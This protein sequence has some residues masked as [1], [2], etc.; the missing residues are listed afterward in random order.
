MKSACRAGG[1]IDINEVSTAA[2]SSSIGRS[3]AFYAVKISDSK[4]S[5]E[6]SESS[7]RQTSFSSVP[8]L[9]FVSLFVFA[10]SLQQS[11]P[12]LAALAASSS[13]ALLSLFV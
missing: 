8:L 12:V 5:F 3:L 6:V 4:Q 7:D 10:S 1:C 9:L 11:L 2:S 13:L